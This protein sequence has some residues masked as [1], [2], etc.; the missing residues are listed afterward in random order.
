MMCVQEV[1]EHVG[2]FVCDVRRIGAWVGGW[3]GGGV[4]FYFLFICLFK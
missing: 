3:W 4:I 1:P 2:V